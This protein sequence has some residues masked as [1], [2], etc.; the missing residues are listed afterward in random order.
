ME[1]YNIN[2]MEDIHPADFDRDFGNYGKCAYT[3]T[4]SQKRKKHVYM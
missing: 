4:S 3:R 2:S 1:T